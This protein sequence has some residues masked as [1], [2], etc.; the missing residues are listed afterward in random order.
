MVA[1]RLARQFREH[2]TLKRL[3]L[4]PLRRARGSEIR[5]LR[6]MKS[7]AVKGGQTARVKMIDARITSV[8]KRFNERVA[9]LEG[10]V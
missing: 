1:R 4:R 5:K 2:V 8:M 3:Q 7:D 10:G 9:A 6:E